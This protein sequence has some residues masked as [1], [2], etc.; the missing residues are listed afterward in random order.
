MAGESL[1]DKVPAGV[2][3]VAAIFFSS[4]AYVLVL[5]VAKLARP[6]SVSLSLGAS[7]LH[8]LELAG[9]YAFLLAAVLG[10]LV[11]YGLLKL[12]NLARRAAI[13]I[14]VAGMIMLLP[15]VSATATDLSPRFFLAGSM[16]VIRVMIAWYLWQ[17]STTER[18]R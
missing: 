9:P 14:A 11:G 16:I 2:A 10:T 15:K 8:G 12:K 4:S 13:A 3:A 7:L 5:G 6:D 18:F 1:S 17:N